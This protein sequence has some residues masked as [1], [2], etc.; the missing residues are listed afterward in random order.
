MIVQNRAIYNNRTNIASDL[1]YLPLT[2]EK[3]IPSLLT[4]TMI[5]SLRLSIQTPRLFY[6]KAVKPSPFLII[7]KPNTCVVPHYL[8]STTK[9]PSTTILYHP[10][11]VTGAVLSPSIQDK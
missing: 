1:C 10:P 8:L 4:M 11:P 5:G 6:T 2:D 3:F 7:C 9:P